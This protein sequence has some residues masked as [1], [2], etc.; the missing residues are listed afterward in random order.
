MSNYVSLLVY[1]LQVVSLLLDRGFVDLGAKNLEGHTDFDILERQTQA[2]VDNQRISDLLMPR[3]R[4]ATSLSTALYCAICLYGLIY[5]LIFPL[6]VLQRQRCLNF[7][8]NIFEK[9]S[10]KIRRQQTVIN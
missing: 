8:K 4:P 6:I 5:C 9:C 2:K 1:V 10:V 7:F 3:K